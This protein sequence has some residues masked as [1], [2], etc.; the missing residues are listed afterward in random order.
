MTNPYELAK[1]GGKHS[2]FYIKYV[3]KSEVEIQ[4]AIRS[5]SKRISD[6]QSWIQNPELHVPNFKALDFRQQRALI[7]NK[8]VSDIARLQEQKAILEGILQARQP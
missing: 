6:H 1:T 5:L 4:R 3:N 2:G 8:W 7:E